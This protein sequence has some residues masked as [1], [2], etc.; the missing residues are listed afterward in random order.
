M[1][2]V[3]KVP[4]AMMLV[5]RSRLEDFMYRKAEAETVIVFVNAKKQCDYV[6]NLLNSMGVSST[7]LHGGKTQDQREVGQN[8]SSYCCS[9]GY[10]RRNQFATA[11]IAPKRA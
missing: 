11:E 5:T 1:A 9:R 10:T 3:T 6:S 4:F 8:T 7:V 2:L